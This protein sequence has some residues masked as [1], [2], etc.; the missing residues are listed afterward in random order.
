MTSLTSSGGAELTVF[1]GEFFVDSIKVA[2]GETLASLLRVGD[3][4]N[5]ADESVEFELIWPFN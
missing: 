2:V 4:T 1:S 3:S 5:G